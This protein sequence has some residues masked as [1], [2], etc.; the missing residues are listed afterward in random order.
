MEAVRRLG[1]AGVPVICLEPGGLL[2]ESVQHGIKPSLCPEASRPAGGPTT[3]VQMEL[4]IHRSAGAK[5][6]MKEGEYN[7]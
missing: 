1:A 5:R 3:G 2:R 4:G 7:G 6:A